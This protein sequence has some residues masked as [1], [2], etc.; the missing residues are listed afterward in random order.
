[1]RT[2]QKYVEINMQDIPQDIMDKHGYITLAI[3]F[4]MNMSCNIHFGMAEL[5]KDMSLLAI[6]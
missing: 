6:Y 4:F 3:P 5:V 1:M 2:T